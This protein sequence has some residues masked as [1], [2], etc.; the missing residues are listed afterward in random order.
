MS[1]ISTLVLYGTQSSREA[2]RNLLEN[3]PQIKRVDFESDQRALRL[4]TTVP[5]N[6][7][8]LIPLLADSGI[9]GIRLISSN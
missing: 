3:Q 4:V 8:N 9:Y 7:T 1:C 6:E 2:A 5:I